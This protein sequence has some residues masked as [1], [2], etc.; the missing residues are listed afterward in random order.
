MYP[1]RLRPSE[2]RALLGKYQ[3]PTAI[4]GQRCDWVKLDRDAIPRS[5]DSFSVLIGEAVENVSRI[6]HHDRG[7][8]RKRRAPGPHFNR[9]LHYLRLCLFAYG[10]LC[11]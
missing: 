4:D 3:A 5:E 11:V 8:R 6:L 2:R 7:E 9:I 1:D 10:A